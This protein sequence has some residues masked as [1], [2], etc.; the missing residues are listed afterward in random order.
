[1]ALMS[2]GPAYMLLLANVALIGLLPTT[3]LT[4]SLT[5]RVSMLLKSTNCMPMCTLDRD[6]RTLQQEQARPPGRVRVMAN[7]T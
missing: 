7:V 5:L 1:M 3:M 2:P 6:L 4:L